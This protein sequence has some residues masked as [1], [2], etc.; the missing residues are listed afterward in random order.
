T[1]DNNAPNA[2]RRITQP[3]VDKGPLTASVVR[4]CI[5]SARSPS[6]QLCEVSRLRV[7]LLPNTAGARVPRARLNLVS[8]LFSTRGPRSRPP[9]LRDLQGQHADKCCSTVGSGARSRWQQ[10]E[11]SQCEQN[12][13]DMGHRT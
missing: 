8:R 1:A 10:W 6:I 5:L 3:P 12:N 2:A 9:N 4:D 11:R 13:G 7:Q